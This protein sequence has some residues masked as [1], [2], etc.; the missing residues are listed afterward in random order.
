ME[1]LKGNEKIGQMSIR[2]NFASMFMQGFASNPKSQILFKEPQMYLIELSVRMAD[3]LIEELNKEP[4]PPN[5][6]RI[7][8]WIAKNLAKR[9]ILRAGNDK[10]AYTRLKGVLQYG[11]DQGHFLYAEDITDLDLMKAR[12]CGPVCRALFFHLISDQ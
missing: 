12:N 9:D 11:Y 2:Q 7:P 6:T 10:G 5:K 1:K 4:E 8:D 3:L